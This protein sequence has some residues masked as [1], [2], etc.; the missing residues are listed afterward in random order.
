MK[1]VL[2]PALFLGIGISPLVNAAETLAVQS[3]ENMIYQYST[4][5]KYMVNPFKV[6]DESKLN[7]TLFTWDNTCNAYLWVPPEIKKIRALIVMGNN[8]PEQR[9][10]GNPKLRE[11]CKELDLAI[12]FTNRSLLM[13]FVNGADNSVMTQQEKARRHLEY[14][15]QI[16]DDLAE[17]SGFS[18]LK[19]VPLIP[20]GES[21][22]LH[23]VNH[24]LNGAEDRVVAGIWLKDNQYHRVEKNTPVL[25][26]CGSGAEWGF[27]KSDINTSW[28]TKAQSDAKGCENL[29]LQRL[30]WPGSLMIEAGSAHFTLTDAMLD[31]ILKY[32][33][34]ACK[35]RLSDDG[36][37][38]L[39]K[40]VFADGYIARLPG[41]GV[42]N[43]M[44]P[45]P[46]KNAVGMERALPWYFDRETAQAAYDLADVN[47][48]A[49]SQIAAFTDKNGNVIPFNFNGVQRST[50]EMEDDAMTF[51]LHA[52]M[53]DVTPRDCKDAGKKL[54]HSPVP[55]RI[56]WLCGAA[57]PLGN[58]KFQLY[59]D[60][61]VVNSNDPGAIMLVIHPGDKDFRLC[62]M[63]MYINIP[64]PREGREQTIDFPAIPDTDRKVKSITLNA[65]SDSGLPV[66]Y[67][68]K[69][70]P[71]VV[72][73]NKLIFKD[74]PENG[75]FPIE[76]SV[77]AWQFGRHAGPK[78][79]RAK[80]V[81]RKFK[82][83]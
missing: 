55:P 54:E 21:G 37:P 11:L 22:H 1:R 45:K 30:A 14:L 44:K 81:E 33:R 72:E 16:L 80:D 71:A 15:Q 32:I 7:K 40:V 65:K 69:Y 9:L 31:A 63:P 67:F 39:K 53:L 17:K 36:S 3:P 59:I 20:I 58:N 78:I 28:K 60:R 12:L 46:Y 48:N 43:P 74:I 38:K 82:L 77:V 56:E 61:N 73:G 13:H 68:V 19:T 70:G 47:W 4:T 8:V 49:K 2:I 29:R 41:P 64:T 66:K 79:K 25:A 50:P 52:K 34:G 18:E 24:F 62:T 26:A 42:K 35:A 23:L 75:K 76:I 5:R 10:A 6:P 51:T 57:K 27:N 83:Y